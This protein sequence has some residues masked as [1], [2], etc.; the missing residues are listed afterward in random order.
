M[1]IDTY[2]AYPYSSL[3]NSEDIDYFEL[4]CKIDRGE[5]E[6]WPIKFHH[7]SKC[8]V[9]VDDQFHRQLVEGVLQQITMNKAASTLWPLI[10]IQYF[11]CYWEYH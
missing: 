3:H 10:V 4:Q 2:S 7:P 8:H 5:A 1:E 9:K 6:N 11:F